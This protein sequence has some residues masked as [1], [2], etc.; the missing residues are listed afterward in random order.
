MILEN[1]KGVSVE[2]GLLC[3]RFSAKRSRAGTNQIA[4]VQ[5][6]PSSELWMACGAGEIDGM[7]QNDTVSCSVLVVSPPELPS[8]AQIFQNTFG[9]TGLLVANR[10]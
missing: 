2:Q 6:S 9:S 8:L 1:E 10:T 7:K 3:K 4:G 5:V